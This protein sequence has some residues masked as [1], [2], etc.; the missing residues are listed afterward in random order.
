MDIFYL[1]VTII[2]IIGIIVGIAQA[3]DSEEFS[4]FF[5]SMAVL[6]CTLIDWI[7]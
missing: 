2:S 1:I 5:C 7:C 4:I 3:I 6:I